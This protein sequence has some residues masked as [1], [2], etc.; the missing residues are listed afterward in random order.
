MT[1]SKAMI[2]QHLEY[3]K[4]R[5]IIADDVVTEKASYIERLCDETIELIN[6]Q[7]KEY[8]NLEELVRQLKETDDDEG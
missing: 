7:E 2:L 6:Q 5:A 1:E 3:L 4:E 8:E